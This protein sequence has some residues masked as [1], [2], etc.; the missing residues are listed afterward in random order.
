MFGYLDCFSGVSGDKFLGALV[1]AGLPA[2]TLRDR[3]AGLGLDGWSLESRDVL[4]AGARGTRVEVLAQGGQPSRSYADIRGLLAG[5]D[6]PEEVRE[7]AQLVF[8]VLARAEARVHDVPVDEV[9]FH[10]VGA[11][12]SIIDIVGV[13]IGLVEL[14]VDELWAS[15]VRLGYGTVETAHGTLPVPAPATAELL[16]GVP[17]YGGDVE[18]E[19]T[20]PTGAALLRAFVTRYAPPPPAEMRAQGYGAGTRDP[21]QIPNLLGLGLYERGPWE[22][23]DELVMLLETVI[24]HLS[25]EQLAVALDMVREA[26]AL[27]VWQRPVVM[28]KGRLAVEVTVMARPEDAPGLTAELMRQTGT[29]GVRRHEVWRSVARRR[30]QRMATDLGVV[31]VK[32]ADLAGAERSRPESDDVA[33]IAREIGEGVAE[34]AK[35]LSEEVSRPGHSG[36]E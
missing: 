1:D 4:R 18:G 11:V 33:R 15:P 14:D 30:T 19:M 28:K 24:D 2:A 8:E 5:A 34:V 16:S 12:D 7:R 29:L 3:L 10:E 27:D 26:G 23:A 13:S 22:G 36:T 20:T 9:H 17:V 31:R 35:K 25:P 32:S 6:L 21:V